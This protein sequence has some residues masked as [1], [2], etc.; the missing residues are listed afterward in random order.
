MTLIVGDNERIAAQGSLT[1]RPATQQ[2]AVVCPPPPGPSTSSSLLKCSQGLPGWYP[3]P[4]PILLFHAKP[5]RN[6]IYRAREPG[7]VTAPMT[8]LKTHMAREMT[9]ISPYFIDTILCPPTRIVHRGLRQSMWGTG[10]G[11]ARVTGSLAFFSSPLSLSL[12]P[13]ATSLCRHH[14]SRGCSK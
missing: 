6:S 8:A 9:M 14:L 3:H 5:A 1:L 11:Q 13:W 4:L 7:W 2:W 12:R 10:C